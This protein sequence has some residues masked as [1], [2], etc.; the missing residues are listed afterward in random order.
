[1]YDE[2][3]KKIQQRRKGAQSSIPD[4]QY[5]EDFLEKNK[6]YIQ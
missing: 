6:D 2:I 1:V 5:V 3:Q 4:R